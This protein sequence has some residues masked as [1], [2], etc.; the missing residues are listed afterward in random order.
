MSQTPLHD[1]LRPRLDL[2]LAEA[3]RAGFDRQAVLAV[4]TDLAT[5][6]AYNEAP[7]PTEPQLPH[8]PWPERSEAGTIHPV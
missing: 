5:S 3:G 8:G 1:W 4:L 6:P 2:V 7:L